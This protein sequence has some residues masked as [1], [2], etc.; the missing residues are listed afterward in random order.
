M[1]GKSITGSAYTNGGEKMDYYSL[2]L[3]AL[4]KLLEDINKG[5]DAAVVEECSDK[6]RSEGN[7]TMLG[8]E[9]APGGRME[10]FRIDGTSI[11]DPVK[12]FWTGQV[13]TALVAM[14]AQ[15]SAFEQRKMKTDLSFM[16]RNFGA[17][18]EIM[19]ASRCAACGEITAT[20]L[21]IDKYISKIVIAKKIVDGMEN[22]ELV[23]ETE[24]LITAEGD[25]ISRERRKAKLRLENSRINITDGFGRLTVCPHCKSKKLT[26]TKLLRS[27]KENVFV[28]LSH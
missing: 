16:R 11:Q 5:S 3:E 22:G 28:P 23:A 8:R 26:Q 20:A 27:L 21:D 15:I 2:T 1:S 17:A 10:Q 18:N 19:Q 25:D 9:F 12:G 4:K 7:C 14:A 13:F 6:W 24:K